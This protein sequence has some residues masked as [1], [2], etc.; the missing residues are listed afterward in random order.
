MRVYVCVCKIL[1]D[2][3]NH[4]ELIIIFCSKLIPLSFHA[5]LSTIIRLFPFKI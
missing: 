3:I 1:E 2:N 5:V 4:I